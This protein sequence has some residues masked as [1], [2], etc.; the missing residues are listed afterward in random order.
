[1]K[2]GSEAGCLNK[3]SGYIVITIDGKP[4]FAHRLAHL[5]VIGSW[6]D[7]NPEHENRIRHDNSWDNI[8]DL[9]GNQ[10]E[11]LGNQSLSRRNTSGAKG[12]SWDRVNRKWHANIEVFGKKITLGRFGDF[13]LAGLHYDAAAKLSWGRRFSCLNFT[14]EESDPLVLPERVT[15]QIEEAIRARQASNS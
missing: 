4:Y 5:L 10:S 3:D 9:A 8:K 7:G 1:V 15:L 13:R 14:P 11:N 6:P 2:A 12:V